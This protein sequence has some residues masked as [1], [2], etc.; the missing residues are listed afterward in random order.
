MNQ[1][2][3]DLKSFDNKHRNFTKDIE[4]D[5]KKYG[6]YASHCKAQKNPFTIEDLR[7]KPAKNTIQS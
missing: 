4:K 6:Q 2:T 5:F 3:E 7:K 1:K